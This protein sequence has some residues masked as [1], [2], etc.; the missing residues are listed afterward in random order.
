MINMTLV[1]RIFMLI[2]FTLVGLFSNLGSTTLERSI[3][4]E[5]THSHEYSDN[6]HHHAGSSKNLDHHNEQANNPEDC[7]D[8]SKEPTSSNQHSHEI[9]VSSGQVF[10]VVAKVELAEVQKFEHIFPNSC[11]ELS[12]HSQYL[13]SI[14]RPPINV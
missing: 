11:E 5:V 7:Q 4:I 13:G 2:V 6:H 3:K 8:S 9:V 1:F 10:T 12:P 14:F